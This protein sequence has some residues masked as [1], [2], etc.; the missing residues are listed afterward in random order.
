[1]RFVLFLS[2]SI[3]SAGP[4]PSW[5]LEPFN[6]NA[7]VKQSQKWQ[8]SCQRTRCCTRD[9]C[10]LRRDCVIRFQ[11]RPFSKSTWYWTISRQKCKVKNLGNWKWS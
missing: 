11:E 5:V 3:Y 10:P 1:M 4:L 9:S 8:F 7:A 6:A 2:N